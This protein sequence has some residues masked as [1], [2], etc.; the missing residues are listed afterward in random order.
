[1]EVTTTVMVISDE[2]LKF[3]YRAVKAFG[4][5]EFLTSL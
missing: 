1:M 4:G 2:K 5:S 3:N